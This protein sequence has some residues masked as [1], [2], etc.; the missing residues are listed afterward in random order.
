MIG[1]IVDNR[2]GVPELTLQSLSAD[3]CLGGALLAPA[4]GTDFR[5]PRRRP[6]ST[7]VGITGVAVVGT[8]MFLS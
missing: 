2:E 8:S 6:S 7:P 4:A 5:R 3:V 1:E